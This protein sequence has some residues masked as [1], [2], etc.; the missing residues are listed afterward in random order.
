MAPILSNRTTLSKLPKGFC[1]IE[2]GVQ[3]FELIKAREPFIFLTGRAGTGKSTFIQYVKENFT[4][5]LV[6]GAPTGVAALNIQGQTIHS[7]FKFPAKPFQN[8]E[9]RSKR[10]EL[11]ENLDLLVID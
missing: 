2:K 5:N 9:I 4:G 8:S 3:V 10:N 11:F 7:L 6:V 1:L